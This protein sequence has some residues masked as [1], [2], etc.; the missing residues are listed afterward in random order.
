MR[1]KTFSSKRS[2]GRVR[3]NF[4]KIEIAKL[5]QYFLFR[6][7]SPT[8]QLH[9]CNIIYLLRDNSNENLYMIVNIY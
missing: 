5:A 8:R 9:I 2:V 6:F 7:L 4:A 1:G 3:L